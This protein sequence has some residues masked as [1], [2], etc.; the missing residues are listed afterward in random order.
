MESQILYSSRMGHT[1]RIADAMASELGTIASDV[2]TAELKDDTL[3]FLGS[4][5]YGRKPGKSMTEFIERNDFASRTVAVFGTS[6]GGDGNEVSEMEAMLRSKGATIKGTYAC[7]G[8]FLYF[9]SRGH[10]NEGDL[11]GARQFARSMME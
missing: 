1:K 3:L 9:F 6:A 2:A 11:E 5:C 10:P 7:R 8:S 4:G